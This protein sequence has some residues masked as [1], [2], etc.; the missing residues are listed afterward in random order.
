M[1]SPSPYYPPTFAD[2]RRTCIQRYKII[3]RH[4]VIT[5]TKYYTWCVRIF[6]NKEFNSWANNLGIS[7]EDIQ[8]AAKEVAAGQHE[9]SLGKKVY[10]KRIA[11]G[12]A[13]K[14]SGSRIIVAFNIGNHM[15]FI[16]GFAKGKRANIT[17]KEKKALQ[18]LASVYL[19]Y[20]DKE[21]NIAVKQKLLFEVEN[22]G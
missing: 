20:S 22:N 7:D 10:K 5:S 8:A 14:S 18:K 21:L 12:N 16:Y 19:N 15:F 13:G 11:I 3:I 2:T 9:A 6:K 17:S 1:A 4:L